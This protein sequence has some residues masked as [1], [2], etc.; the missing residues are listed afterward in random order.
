[1]AVTTKRQIRV[2]IKPS[3]GGAE[4]TI[5]IMLAPNPEMDQSQLIA[6][7]EGSV[8]GALATAWEGDDG[9]TIASSSL[10]TI[11]TS[12]NV[13]IEDYVIS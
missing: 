2:G 6:A 1:M 10:S 7:Y 5:N 13:L 4:K 8:A 11:T 3:S 9:S 12:T